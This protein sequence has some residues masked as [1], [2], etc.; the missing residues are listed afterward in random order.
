M[1]RLPAAVDRAAGGK[2]A[3]QRAGATAAEPSGAPA[4][5]ATRITKA[6]LVC[7]RHLLRR[8]AS[9]PTSPLGPPLSPAAEASCRDAARA[10]AAA[11]SAVARQSRFLCSPM[12]SLP[13]KPPSRPF[14]PA[15][16]LPTHRSWR[17]RR[18][19]T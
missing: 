14:S 6:L 16:A 2:G 12:P 5:V 11:Q 7:G 17:R 10:G 3:S 9:S 1:E 8:S 4:R 13:L 19:P 18:R 15:L